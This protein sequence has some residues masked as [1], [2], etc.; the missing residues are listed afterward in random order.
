[1]DNPHLS[2][3]GVNGATGEYFFQPSEQELTDLILGKGMPAVVDKAVMPG[4]RPKDLAS[5]GWGVVFAEDTDPAIREALSPLL[6][7]RQDLTPRFYREYLGTDGVWKGESKWRFLARHGVG[8]GPVNPK[9]VPYYLLIA[10][11]PEKIPFNFQHQ[12]GVQYAVGRL[13]FDTPE[14]YDQYARN[15]VAAET[16]PEPQARRATF[17]GVQNPDDNPTHQST[18]HLLQPLAKTLSEDRR[19][20]QIDSRLGAAATKAELGRLLG[21]EDR[22]S[23][24][25]TTSHGMLFNHGHPLQRSHQ[26]ALLCQDWPGPKAWKGAVP[27]DHYFAAQDVADSADLRGMMTFHF[28]C[29]GA[30]VPERDSFGHE[31]D[32]APRL[33]APQPFVSRLPQRLLAH[34]RGALATIGHVDKAWGW[35]FYWRGAGN[36][37]DPFEAV[38][39]SLMEGEPVGYAMRYF[40]DRYGQLAVDLSATLEAERSTGEASNEIFDLWTA[41]NDA[42]SYAILGDPAVR[43]KVDGEN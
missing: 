24:L 15:V 40:G 19:D 32:A 11:G 13:A 6:E 7:H 31:D 43:M 4:V 39:K 2:F 16:D 9:K 38:L 26:G 23:L 27:E 21:G 5:S 17:F 10:G 37:P 42:R 18:Q 30:G 12:L 36:Q 3:N 33:L 35:S 41:T 1:M 25:F 8:P 34:P 29:F 20:W 22:P 28:A 14:E